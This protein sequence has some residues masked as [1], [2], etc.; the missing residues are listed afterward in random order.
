L[1]DQDFKTRRVGIER[2]NRKRTQQQLENEVE[3]IQQEKLRSELLK[4]QIV[5]RQ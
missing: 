4:T 3:A 5:K 1:K 2:D